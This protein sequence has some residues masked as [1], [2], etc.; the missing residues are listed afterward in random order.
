MDFSDLDRAID[1]RREHCLDTLAC[2]LRQPSISAQGVGVDECAV[3]VRDILEEHGIPARLLPTEGY[4]VVYGE[5]HVGDDRNTILIYGHYDVQPP[6]PYEQWVSPPF[7]PTIRDGRIYARGAGDNK[8][9]FVAHILAIKLLDDLGQL[10]DVNIKFILE[11]EEESGS[12][13][14]PRFV[15]ENA[16]LLRA[17][18][19]YAADGP[20]HI[21]GRPVVFFGVR[22]MLKMELE[23]TGANRD[24][25]SGN[26]GGPVP[27][28]AWTLVELLASMRGPDGRVTIEGFYDGVQPPSDFER[29]LLGRIPFD[30]ETFKE[31]LGIDRFDGP[32]DQSYFEKIMFEPTLTING[33]TG[34]YGGAGSKSV[35]PSKATAKLESRLAAGQ[36]PDAV[37]AAVARHVERHA[38]GVVIRNLGSTRPS[39]T[40]TELPVSRLVTT[41][42]RDAYG[43][44]PVVMP[45][46]GASS[47]NYLFTDV[48]A[49][50]AIWVTYGPPD[51]NNHAPNENM[52]L[53]SFFNGIRASAVLLQRFGTAPRSEVSASPAG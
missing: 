9:Q 17:D 34:G 22:G 11:G 29:E 44:E 12:P 23:A 48:L 41:A 49:Q 4:P 28:A 33:I 39:K 36:D 5:R 24:L 3:L 37:F 35:I 52:T 14:L 40:S 13:N 32:A 50:P 47:P 42:I 30:A 45:L 19:F 38:P 2:L 27:N 51:E 25:H 8:G 6:E 7:E 43:V 16:D 10:P 53:E 1:A 26:F 20:A 31:N 21:S 46:L 18:L 15:E